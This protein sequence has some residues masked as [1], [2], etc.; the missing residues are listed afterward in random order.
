MVQ[1][2]RTAH[3]QLEVEVAVDAGTEERWT[4]AA[5]ELLDLHG[6]KRGFAP[7]TFQGPRRLCNPEAGLLLNSWSM[8]SVLDGGGL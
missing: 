1:K 8:P 3:K 4:H 7:R 2:R 6:R 5:V